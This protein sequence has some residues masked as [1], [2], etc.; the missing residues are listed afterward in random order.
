MDPRKNIVLI[1]MAGVGKST[2]GVLLA[3]ALAR[4][5]IDTDVRIQAAEGRRLQDIID[6]DGLDAFLAKEERYVLDL[7]VHGAVIATGGS[8]V[9]SPKA[10]AHLKANGTVVYLALPMHELESRVT[11]MDSR[12]L[13]IHPGQTF[14]HLYEEREPLY[15]EYAD[16][17]INCQGHTHDQIVYRILE[18]LE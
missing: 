9:Y 10:M 2:I 18:F 8:V 3:K 16:V 6:A 5:F 14:A 13:V 12:G 17:K 11:N 15:E 1:G 7:D 4:P